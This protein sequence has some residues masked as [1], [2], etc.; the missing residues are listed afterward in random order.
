MKSIFSIFLLSI[1]LSTLA[2]ENGIA[3]ENFELSGHPKSIQL[4][5]QKGKYVVLEWYNEGCP[6]VRKHY[7]SGNIPKMQKKYQ[8]KVSWLAIASSAKGKQ[9]Y[10][11]NISKAKELYTKEQMSALS[12]LLDSDGIVGNQFGAKTTPHFFIINPEGK[13]IYQGGID[14]IASANPADIEQADN[15][16]AMALDEALAGKSIT[17]AKTRPYGCSVKY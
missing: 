6:F 14:S 7:D 10:V 4:K 8:D 17:Q 11:E 1:S 3:P 5:D 2:L 9:G 13:V 16:V 12:L 15:Y